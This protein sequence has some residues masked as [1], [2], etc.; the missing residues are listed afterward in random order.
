MK[1]LF[2]VLCLI[3]MVTPCYAHSGKL[4]N[5]GGHK[6]NKEW[7]YEGKYI[8]I[9]DNYPIMW[10]GGKVFKEGDYHFHCKPSAN[11]IDFSTYRDGIY[12]PVKDKSEV[13]E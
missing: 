3:F 6:V 13:E 9:V 4:D 8:E 7:I 1:K 2:T 10:D 5:T 11:R 12:I